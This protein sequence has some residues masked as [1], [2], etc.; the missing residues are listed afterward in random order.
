M[1]SR[2]LVLFAIALAGVSLFGMAAL[3]TLPEANATGD[4]VVA[5][6][7]TRGE[8]V[9]W[10]VWA[11]T[12]SAPLF[13][14]VAAM[15]RRYIP[16]PHRDV[17][18]IGAVSVVVTIAVQSWFWGGL[19]LHADT[20]EPATARAVLDIAV[21]WGPVLTGAWMTMTAP[22]TLLAF[23]RGGVLPKWLGILGAVAF[24]EQAAETVTIFGSGGFT[25][26]G[27]AMNLQLGAGITMVWLLAFAIWAGVRGHINSHS[28]NGKS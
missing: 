23:N 10:A 11:G 2:S 21:F 25:Q 22:V 9:R 27:G 28:M 1:S 5:W 18:L 16:E 7:R 13:A 4:E 17:F 6:F 8:R 26:P 19:A 3:G 20:L 14:V 24:A 15:L 12:V